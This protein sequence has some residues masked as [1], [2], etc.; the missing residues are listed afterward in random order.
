MIKA[1]KIG[2]K[3][4]E[5]VSE[6]EKILQS[7]DVTLLAIG[8]A[9]SKAITISEIIKRNTTEGSLSQTNSLTKVY[10]AVKEK[11]SQEIDEEEGEWKETSQ[12]TKSKFEPCLEITLRRA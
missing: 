1:I 9:I 5:A 11:G 6:V 7:D 3:I 8:N 2:T 4:N 12:S 10:R